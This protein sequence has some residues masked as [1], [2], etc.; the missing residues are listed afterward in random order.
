MVD[1]HT[2]PSKSKA[3]SL[4]SLL[5]TPTNNFGLGLLFKKL[6]MVGGHC[7]MELVSIQ[8]LEISSF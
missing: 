6:I 1:K 4:K 5:S 7:Q 3:E 8:R 2:L